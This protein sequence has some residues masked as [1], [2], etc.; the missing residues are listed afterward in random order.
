VVNHND[1]VEERFVIS[2][3]SWSDGDAGVLKPTY[4]T[5]PIWRSQRFQTQSVTKWWYRKFYEETRTGQFMVLRDDAQLF[6]YESPR[7]QQTMIVQL[8]QETA[9]R[10]RTTNRLLGLVLAIGV[11]SLLI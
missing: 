8:S 11:L 3:P 5:E 7:N 9:R 1:I 2:A 4:D 10:Q 6:H